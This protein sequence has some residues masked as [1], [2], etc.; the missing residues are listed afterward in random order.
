MGLRLTPSCTVRTCHGEKRIKP[1]MP[2]LRSYIQDG[3]GI[4]VLEECNVFGKFLLRTLSLFAWRDVCEGSKSN[5]HPVL[6]PWHWT[7]QMDSRAGNT[8]ME[9]K[10]AREVIHATGMH[11]A[12]GVA[13]SLSTQHTLARDGADAAIGKSGRHDAARLTGDLHRT[14]L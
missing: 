10:L 9:G 5:L 14:Q 2:L 1:S 12:E 7:W 11:E 13:H 8:H 4:S 6:S 3:K